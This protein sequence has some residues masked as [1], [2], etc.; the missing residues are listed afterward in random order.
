MSS[1][2]QQGNNTT[3]KFFQQTQMPELWKYTNSNNNPYYPNY[4]T[5]SNKD[6]N[7]YIPNTLVVG[8]TVYPSDIRL[9]ENIQ[10]IRLDSRLMDSLM[11]VTPKQYTMKEDKEK[12]VVPLH[13]GFIA[14]EVET[15]IPEL[16]L[17]FRSIDKEEEKE[18][19]TINYLE[20][21]PLLLMKIQDLQN[22]VDELKENIR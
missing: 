4:I 9:K 1:Y 17:T 10:D 5:P 3:V 13:F 7:V 2:K 12:D 20:M 19:K 11:Q 22:Q 21:I 14:Q 8:T 6:A 15:Y 16:I 18:I